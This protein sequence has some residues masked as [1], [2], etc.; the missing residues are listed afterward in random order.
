MITA[1]HQLFLFD[2]DGTI[3]DSQH[4]IVAAMRKAFV[5]MQL[6]EPDAESVRRVVG[7]SLVEA[8]DRLLPQAVNPEIV[9]EHY[10]NA[11][12][13]LRQAHHLS[14]PLY[15]GAAEAISTLNKAGHLLGI[16]TGK[17]RRGLDRVLE[18]HA[19]TN[20]FLT[21]QT[22]DNHPGKPHPSMIRAAAADAG[23]LTSQVVMIGDTS[24]DM[25]MAVNA[26]ALA[27]GV[28]W[29]YHPVEELKAAGATVVVDNYTSL[30]AL[31]MGE[32]GL[33]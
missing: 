4:L 16:A 5:Q 20:H 26:G 15:P 21:L 6:P 2:C 25:E 1:E 27:I 33:G 7:L 14:E 22:A 31:L 24:F 11:F 18:I 29:G 9:A 10:K 13:H 8:C 12:V 17:S 19:L 28:A 3:V 23:V 30:L 32:K